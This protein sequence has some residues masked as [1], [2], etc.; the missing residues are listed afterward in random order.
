M[1][2]RETPRFLNVACIQQVY[3]KG[4]HVY[5]EMTDYTEKCVRNTNINTFLERFI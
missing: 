2:D 5:I 3:Q 1:Q 4:E